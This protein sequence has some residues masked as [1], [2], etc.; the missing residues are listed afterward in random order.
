MSPRSSRGATGASGFEFDVDAVFRGF[1]ETAW[2][3]LDPWFCI[4]E[5]NVVPEP[6]TG[7]LLW[8]GSVQKKAGHG[9]VSWNGKTILVHRAAFESQCGRI[10]AGYHVHHMCEQPS[11]VNVDH[12][13][14]V[15]PE[16]HRR[17]HYGV[18]KI[19]R[20]PVGEAPPP[21]AVMCPDGGAA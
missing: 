18:G 1:A 8:L 3:A 6:N 7:C 2:L 19:I 12:L 11:C 4:I 10:P 21:G 17:I 16:Q 13:V 14:L 20:V 5:P 9:T 15:T